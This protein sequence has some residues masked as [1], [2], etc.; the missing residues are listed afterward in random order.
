MEG[1]TPRMCVNPVNAHAFP[2]VMASA[3]I[4]ITGVASMQRPSAAPSCPISACLAHA[5]TRLRPARSIHRGLD[6]QPA[7][8]R[9]PCLLYTSPSPRD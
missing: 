7:A 9:S 6:Q 1:L 4:R 8:D 3:K 2:H 5:S